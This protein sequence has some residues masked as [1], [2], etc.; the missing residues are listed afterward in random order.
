MP[1]ADVTHL[2]TAYQRLRERLE[3][4]GRSEWVLEEMEV[5]TRPE[6]Y[7]ADPEAMWE[8]LRPRTGN[9]RMLGVLRAIAAWREREAQRVNIPAPT[10][11][12]RRE[13]AG[14]GRHRAH[15]RRG[16]GPL[17]RPQPRV[18]RRTQRHRP[19]GGDRHG[20]GAAGGRAARTRRVAATVHGPPLPWCRCS[21]CC[22]PPNARSMTS[23]P[24]WSLVRRHRPA[25]GGGG[26]GRAGA[27][28]LAASRVRRRRIGAEGR[29]GGAGRGGQRVKLIAAS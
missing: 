7:R 3:R 9:R 26:T 27:G 10:P 2:H 17:P 6:T 19:A 15:E 24:S 14:G 28:W 18:R 22:W 5:L 20:G 16:S 21:R 11:V 12:A 4:D 23:P 8:R 29:P 1:A 13:P 25:V